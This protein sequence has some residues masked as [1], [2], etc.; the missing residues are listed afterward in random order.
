MRPYSRNTSPRAVSRA[1][2][3]VELLVV[4]AIIGVLVALLLPAIQAAREA[5]RRSQCQNNLKQIGLGVQ[6]HHNAK[7]FF[8][9]ARNAGDERSVSWA[10]YLLPFMEQNAMFQA[11]RVGTKSYSPANAITFQTPVPTLYCP[12][13]RA[14]VADRDFDSTGVSETIPPESQGHAAGGDYAANAGTL[15]RGANVNQLDLSGPIFTASKIN[16]RQVTDG[17]SNTFAVGEKFIG[18]TDP[19]NPPEAGMECAA[20]G[21]CAIF[22]GNNPETVMR[23]AD[24]GFPTGQGYGASDNE[25]FGSTHTD[26]A[27]FAYLDGSVR[28][29]NYSINQIVFENLGNIADDNPI[30][31]Y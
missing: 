29:I 30:G 3:L 22:D 6:L 20:I 17:L 18:A 1:F 27:N 12:S 23:S 2:T 28:P 31:D 15:F 14:P 26:L 10:F 5:A 13:R 9:T 16:E 25:R 24:K 7:K 21:D 4:I 11:Y 8:P 19:D